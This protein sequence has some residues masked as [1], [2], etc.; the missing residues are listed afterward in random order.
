MKLV[1]AE[2][3]HLT[4]GARRLIREVAELPNR[5]PAEWYGR[6]SRLRV[7]F[8]SQAPNFATGLVD[9]SDGFRTWFYLVKGEGSAALAAGLTALEQKMQAAQRALSLQIAMLNFDGIQADETNCA[10]ELAKL[11]TA[12]AA[13]AEAMAPFLNGVSFADAVA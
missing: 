2:G 4:A 12:N 13:F 3:E 1:I 5:K 6:S 9:H 10:G 11:E 7:K 8:I